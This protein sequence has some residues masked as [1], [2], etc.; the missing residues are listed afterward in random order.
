MRKVFKS[1]AAVVASLAVGSSLALAT[2]SDA[3]AA[4]CGSAAQCAAGSTP[5]LSYGARNPDVARLQR[6][7][8]A[9]GNSVPDTG[10]FGSMTKSAVIKYQSS[11]G[12]RSSGSADGATWRSL[13][14]NRGGAQ[15]VDAPVQVA[16]PATS[17]R[18]DQAISFARAQLG[19]PYSY[20]ATGPGA[21]DCS[22]L[23]MGAMRAAGVSVPRTSQAQYAA[24][25]K[26]S[27]RDLQPGDLVAYYGGISHIGIYIGNGQIIHASRPGRPVAVVPVNSMPVAGAVRY[28]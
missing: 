19:K 4:P 9:A 5:T 11:H 22:G 15:A 14:G 20:G 18:A 10:Y 13:Q 25:R 16:A 23:T 1:T 3:K 28:L 7:L 27:T 12:L 8:S 24:G 26:V 17:N 21:Y 6:A 2:A